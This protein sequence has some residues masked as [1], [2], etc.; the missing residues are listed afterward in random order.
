M[1]N[2]AFFKCYI[3]KKINKGQEILEKENLIENLDYELANHLMRENSKLCYNAN[4]KEWFYK[5][6]PFKKTTQMLSYKKKTEEGIEY[7]EIYTLGNKNATEFNIEEY[8]KNKTN[9]FESLNF[10]KIPY[11]VVNDKVS[12]FYLN[13]LEKFTI[14]ILMP[15]KNLIFL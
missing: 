9:D 1:I 3:P 4:F 15:L 14:M 10:P 13:R 11:V 2:G 8:Y 6:C 5:L 12:Y 7:S